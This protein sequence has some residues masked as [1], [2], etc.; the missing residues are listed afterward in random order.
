MRKFGGR[1]PT[2]DQLSAVAVN[3]NVRDVAGHD[4]SAKDLRMWRA[5]VV[6]AHE[7]PWAEARFV[8]AD[9]LSSSSSSPRVSVRVVC[10][11]AAGTVE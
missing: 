10:S 2:E 7:L 9:V 1:A 5:T 8:P 11:P 6:A 4:F 3:D